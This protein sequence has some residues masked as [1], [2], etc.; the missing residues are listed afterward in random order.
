MS[1]SLEIGSR[2]EPPLEPLHFSCRSLFIGVFCCAL[3]CGFWFW[4]IEPAKEAKRKMQCVNNLKQIGLGLHNYA[5]VYKLLPAAFAVDSNQQPMHSWRL[6]I[7]WLSSSTGPAFKDPFRYN[8]RWDSPSNLAN[9]NRM[10]GL[11]YYCPSSPTSQP[12]THANYVMPV[13]PGAISDGAS[14]TAFSQ[15]RDGLANTI[16][17]AEVANSDIYWTE[18]R[19]L[20]LERMSFRVNDRSQP[21][22]SSAHRG[23]AVVVF[24]DGHTQ[25]LSNSIDPNVLRAL[26]T[27]DGGEAI[28]GDF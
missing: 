19:D 27:I 2:M 15:I 14:Y 4:I 17:A 24:A 10:G 18:P 26:L 8:E 7:L 28:K 5:D 11:T 16:A 3:A 6:S 12:R 20:P 1:D 22:I 23:A 25:A 21:S 13:G 9:S